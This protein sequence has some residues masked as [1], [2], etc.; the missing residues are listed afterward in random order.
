MLDRVGCWL[1]HASSPV[2]GWY[3]VTVSASDV[4]TSLERCGPSAMLAKWPSDWVFW[5]NVLPT[6]FTDSATAAFFPVTYN[7]PVRGLNDIDPKL[8]PPC[9][10]MYSSLIEY[11]V[12]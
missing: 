2:P 1:C 4:P 11:G 10:T 8:D 6:G 7:N 3:A 9:E 12:Y 5:R